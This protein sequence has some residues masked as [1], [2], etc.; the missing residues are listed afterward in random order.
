MRDTYVRIAEALA[1]HCD[2]FL[3]ETLSTALEA[4]CAASAVAKHGELLGP[5]CVRPS[6]SY[7]NALHA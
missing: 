6:L 3:C 2:L 1:P 7:S 4:Q 5:S